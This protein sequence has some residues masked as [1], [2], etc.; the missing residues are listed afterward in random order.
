MSTSLEYDEPLLPKLRGGLGYTNGPNEPND[1]WKVKLNI[2]IISAITLG[3]LVFFFLT[4][5]FFV[6]V[7]EVEN[8]IFRDEVNTMLDEVQ[9]V[10][11]TVNAN[12]NIDSKRP[13]RTISTNEMRSNPDDVQRW[14]KRNDEVKANAIQLCLFVLGGLVVCTAISAYF[15]P[16]GQRFKLLGTVWL[17][18]LL[19]LTFIGTLE[20]LFLSIVTSQFK[21]VAI[22]QL[23]QKVM[24]KV[25][26]VMSFRSFY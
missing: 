20:W 18:A 14:K 15:L 5:F 8:E 7:S 16:E 26:E 12:L 21:T 10:S 4:T 23:K 9:R 22:V 3:T 1:M 11:D 6:Y 24:K 13:R 17:R 25:S 2:G 19:Y